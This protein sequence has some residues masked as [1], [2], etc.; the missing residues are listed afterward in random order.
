MEHQGSAPAPT[1]PVATAVGAG[2]TAAGAVADE[3]T[4][5]LDA[6]DALLDEVDRALARLDDGVY[7]RC[8][9]CGGPIDDDRLAD[10]PT[11]RTCAA[12]EAPDVP[13]VPAHE[14]T[15]TWAGSYGGVDDPTAE[16]GR[17]AG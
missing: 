8:E 3:H 5:T 7:G 17:P 11:V 16:P 4:A 1:G 13:A 2:P 14:E 10:L 15:T 6:V 9:S 12:C